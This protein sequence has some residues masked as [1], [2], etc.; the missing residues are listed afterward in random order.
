[1]KQRHQSKPDAKML[2]AKTGDDIFDPD[3]AI[4]S[5]TSVQEF[6]AT[7]APRLVGR[8][9]YDLLSEEGITGALAKLIG[10]FDAIEVLG[11]SA[12]IL[13]GLFGK[14]SGPIMRFSVFLG[15]LAGY[16]VILK[17]ISSLL[18]SFVRR[19]TREIE[20]PLPPEPLAR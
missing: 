7:T 13:L 2:S 10:G 18:W 12:Y 15:L 3:S 5:D 8:T 9:P 1:M 20:K 19:W 17:P 14:S 6:G 16:H 11:T 4:A